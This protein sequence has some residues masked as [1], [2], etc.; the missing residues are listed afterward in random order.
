MDKLEKIL[1]IIIVVCLMIMTGVVTL[2]ILTR[3]FLQNPLGWSEEVTRYLFIYSTFLAAS[4]G[5]RHGIHIGVDI[6]TE[7]IS[8][9]SKNILRFIVSVILFLFVLLLIYYGSVLSIDNWAQKSPSLSLPM[10]MFY[11][12]IPIGSLLS[13]IFIFEDI[14]LQIKGDKKI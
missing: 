3:Y 9:V 13:L 2:Q 12:A 11:A 5:V 4:V 7:R 8:G 6:L 14:L 1:K 10:G